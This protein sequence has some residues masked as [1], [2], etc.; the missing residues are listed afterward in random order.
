MIRK[1]RCWISQRLST[2]HYLFDPRPFCRFPLQSR[3]LFCVYS[4]CFLVVLFHTHAFPHSNQ[5]N[6]VWD[7]LAHCTLQFF[8][9]DCAT[10]PFFLLVCISLAQPVVAFL[11]YQK[12]AF[13]ASSRSSFFAYAIY[14]AFSDGYPIYLFFSWALTLGRFLTKFMYVLIISLYVISVISGAT[15]NMNYVAQHIRNSPE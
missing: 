10:S 11:S 1:S 8:H 4:I 14:Q 5:V 3:F 12:T 13:S 2:P 6:S 9:R 15:R 7:T